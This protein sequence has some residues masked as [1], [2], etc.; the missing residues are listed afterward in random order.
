M[1]ILRDMT[2]ILKNDFNFSRLVIAGILT[3]IGVG[4]ASAVAWIIKHFIIRILFRNRFHC[5][6]AARLKNISMNLKKKFI[7]SPEEQCG[8][9]SKYD[10]SGNYAKA[11]EWYR[12][13]AERG[14]A[15]AQFRLGFMYEYGKGVPKD[16]K[17][18]RI[19]YKKASAQ[20]DISAKTALNI[21]DRKIK[22][23]M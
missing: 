10:K 7:K 17:E 6:I 13:S 18:A 8:I 2:E 23:G 16:I 4:I 21:M 5:D 3:G 14:Y 19:W 20:G 12:K 15:E 11:A 1:E 22:G 9:G